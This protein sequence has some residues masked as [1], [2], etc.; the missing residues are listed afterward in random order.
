LKKFLNLYGIF[1]FGLSSVF[2]L[3]YKWSLPEFCWSVWLAG[4]FY[5]WGCILTACIQMVL[6]SRS[7]KHFYEKHLPFLERIS[8]NIFLLGMT[9]LTVLAGLI[10]F[11]MYNYLFAFYGLF[12]SVFAQMEPLEL[13]GASGFINSDFYTPV[14][15][16]TILFW[17]MIL[18][19]LIAHWEDFFR[20]NP[21]KRFFL[22]FHKEIVRM[23][24]MVLALPVI[25]MIM[26]ALF[27][28]AYQPVTVV[29]LMGFFYLMPSKSPGE[30]N[31]ES[32]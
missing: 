28:E 4:L 29:I 7:E 11:R 9:I 31:S 2:A 30:S 10:A 13:F 19:T 18:G 20:Q 17:P 26:W 1:G 14:F 5:A 3:I 21:G 23:H 22:P 25:T 32:G 6:F 15:Y 16:L 24:L 12:L 27:G 8:P